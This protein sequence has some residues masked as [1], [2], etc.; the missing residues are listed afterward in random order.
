MKKIA[1]LLFAFALNSISNGQ[2][3]KMDDIRMLL[4]L[5]G[6]DKTGNQIASQIISIYKAD[7]SDDIPGVWDTLQVVINEG[8]GDLIDSI[9][10]IYDKLYTHEEIKSIIEI[11]QSPAGKK[12][13]ETMPVLTE[14]SMKAGQNWATGNIEKIQARIAPLIE[15]Y[16]GKELTYD[17]FYNPDEK[18]DYDT[19]KKILCA[20]SNRTMTQ[21]SPEYKYS[22][23]YDAQKWDI[24]P[25]ETVNPIA[26]LTF[27]SKNQ[28]VYAVLIAETEIFT[29]QQLKAAAIYNMSKASKETRTESTGLR[30]VNGKEMLCMKISCKIDGDTYK[31]YN[32]YYAGDWGILQFIVMTTPENYDNNLKDMEDLLS[33][34]F[35]E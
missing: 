17:D 7:N 13:I 1:L 18:Y 6:A 25:N 19:K 30:N 16:S 3:S 27:S 23:H 5:T 22:V 11:Y 34:I 35:V 33:G 29:I 15:K 4:D 2:N 12:I 10:H 14:L 8:M 26:D 20:K 9:A 24:V 21:G 28:E 32:Y 31:Y